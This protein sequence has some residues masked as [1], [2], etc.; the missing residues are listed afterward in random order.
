M[1]EPRAASGR[2]ELGLNGDWQRFSDKRSATVAGPQVKWAHAIDE[3]T[4]VGVVALAGWRGRSAR[5][6]GA[7]LYAPVTVRLAER[8]WLHANIG[9]NW[10]ADAPATARL[11]V[12]FEWQAAPAW[13]LTGEALR[14]SGASIARV[15]VRWQPSVRFSVDLSRAGGSDVAGSWWSLGATSTSGPRT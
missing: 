13:S 8:V 7:A 10:P 14:Q 12:A 15:G 4:S 9:H 1:P 11:G 5:Y 3:R 2:S 6:A